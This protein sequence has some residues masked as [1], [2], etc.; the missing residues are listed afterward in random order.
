MNILKYAFLAVV[1]LL[2]NNCSD[3]T[4]YASNIVLSPMFNDNMVLQRNK[5]ISVWGTAIPGGVVKIQFEDKI[6][7]TTVANDSSWMVKLDAHAAGGPYELK[8][9]GKDT[10]SIK[11]V[12]VGEVWICSGQSNMEMPL[13]LW[14]NTHYKQE[15]ETADYPEIRL[16]TVKKAI[17]FT[18][19]KELLLE[20]NWEICSPESAEKFSAV[21]Y[22]FAKK[23][24][25]KLKVPIGIIH[26]S[27]GGTPVEAWTPAEDLGALNEFTE[28][29]ESFATYAVNKQRLWKKYYKKVDEWKKSL[30]TLF[31]KEYDGVLWEGSEFDDS[32]WKEM[33]LP[34]Y[35]ENAGMKDTDGIVWF[36]RTFDVPTN[37][38]GKTYI[39][40]L[41]SIDDQDVTYINGKIVG[42]RQ[43]YA[44]KR[45]YTIDENI[46]HKG[47]NTIAIMVR[48]YG[49][50]GGFS[51]KAEEM[52][53]SVG[54]EH[55]SL[56]GKWKYKVLLDDPNK[57][58]P[59]SEQQPS[60]P[61]SPTV[62]YNAMINPLIPYSM[63]GVIWYQGESNASDAVQYGKIFPAMI[64]AWRRE[65]DEG[66]FPFLFVQLA[67][68]MERKDNPDSS[69]WAMLR[70]AQAQALSLPNT[71]MAVAID[72]GEGETIH[73]KNKQEVGRRLYLNALNKVYQEKIP[74]RGAV[75]AS[76]KIDK[77]RITVKFSH[78]EGVLTTTND[79]PPTGFAIAGKDGK[80]VNALTKIVGNT[81]VVW[82]NSVLE[83]VHIRYAWADNPDVNLINE[84]GLP[85]EPFRTDSFEK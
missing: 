36:R 17:S 71:G 8:V 58:I 10:I 39:L 85:T 79:L 64:S 5:P 11:N 61:S 74:F 16:L 31:A 48:D 32:K 21:G 76:K 33:M 43:L 7:Q 28:K 22:F 27:W 42:S 25:K 6:K 51:G 81:V 63:Q 13:N 62:L 73:P 46:L 45:I 24:Y 70:E 77:G 66:D 41:G 9:I 55:I 52:H 56:R 44:D 30:D 82:S 50:N 29:I 68:F 57:K 83:P 80:Y 4:R 35:W 2:L 72:I 47:T 49:G 34:N 69:D 75:Y 20:K 78:T 26:S 65:W 19:K 37:P 67:N 53:L 23:L 59:W 18:K 3:S 15:I 14:G 12:L 1:I 38:Q 40:N 84:A 54:D 60:S